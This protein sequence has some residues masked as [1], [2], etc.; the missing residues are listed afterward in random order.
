MYDLIWLEDGT[1]PLIC[2][3]C[4]PS[5]ISLLPLPLY[6]SWQLVVVLVTPMLYI[7]RYFIPEGGGC[8]EAVGVGLDAYVRRNEQS[9]AIGVTASV[10][11]T[12]RCKRFLI[13]DLQ[14]ALATFGQA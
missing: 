8:V 14:A 7:Y 6:Q 9:H 2:G 1:M 3:C 5:C 11:T 12:R 4:P 10:V 13:G